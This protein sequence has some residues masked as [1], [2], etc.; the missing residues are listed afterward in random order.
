[1]SIIHRESL[2]KLAVRLREL[3]NLV[4]DVVDAQ[5]AVIKLKL[6]E[7]FAQG[8]G[9]DGEA[10]PISKDLLNEPLIRT[11]K[12]RSSF[13]VTKSGKGGKGLFGG[14]LANW[15]FTVSSNLPYAAIQ[16]Y[17]GTLPNGGII[18]PH[19]IIPYQWPGGWGQDLREAV[20]LV[21]RRFWSQRR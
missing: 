3:P 12:L 4:E 8:V 5:V 13:A 9:P 18:P 15:R 20:S 6:A 19:Q 21:M 11:G 10:W 7:E 16:H 2:F 14:S 17:G 1:M